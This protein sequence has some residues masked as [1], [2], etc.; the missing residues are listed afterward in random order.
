MRKTL[1]SIRDEKIFRFFLE[2]FFERKRH[3]Y[4][5]KSVW[6]ALYLVIFIEIYK[7]II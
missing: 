3:R 1:L 5:I 6:K 4:C 7:Y 2:F